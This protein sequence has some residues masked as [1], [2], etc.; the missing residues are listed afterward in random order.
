MN[1]KRSRAPQMDLTRP[2]TLNVSGKQRLKVNILKEEH[3]FRTQSQLLEALLALAEE[4]KED[5]KSI[6]AKIKG[7]I[8]QEQDDYLLEEKDDSFDTGWIEA[9][10]DM[11]ELPAV[12]GLKVLSAAEFDEELKKNHGMEAV[13]AH[14]K[15]IEEYTAKQGQE[16]K[17]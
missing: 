4:H 8:S 5:F 3:N 16:K 2:S 11:K 1:K 7:L 12:S 9:V 13:K 6:S 15:W 17:N 10:F 14:S